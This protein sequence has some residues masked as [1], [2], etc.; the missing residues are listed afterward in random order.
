M[1]KVLLLVGLFVYLS[2]SYAQHLGC[3][4]SHQADALIKQ[5]LMDNRNKFTKQEIK[6]LMNNRTVTYI[7]VSIHNVSNSV[8]EGAATEREIFN[9]LCGLNDLYASQDVQF[10]IYNQINAQTSNAID[11]DASSNASRQAMTG[12]R[13][14]GTMNITIGRS[15]SNP[16][17]SWYS[18]GPDY[19]FLLKQMMSAEAKTEAHEVGHFFTLPHTF[20]GW[21]QT[22]V[23]Q[24]NNQNVPAQVPNQWGWTFTPEHVARTGSQA[25]CSTEGD[26][27]CDTEADYFS[28]RTNC[29]YV[30]LA[31]DPFGNSLTPDDS[32]IMSYASDQCVS[33]FSNQQK[34]AVAMDIATRTWVS[35]TPGSTVDLTAEPATTPVSP[36]NNA[37]LGPISNSTVRID[38]AD[39]NGAT[40]Y[41]LE[42]YGT[43]IPGIW[44]ADATDV[45]YKG[46]LYSSNSYFDLS[47][48]NLQAG[49]RYAW[50]VTP[51]SNYSTCASA[52]PYYRFE[53]SAL[54]TSVK[55]LALEQQMTIKVLEQPVTTS[56]IALAIYTA[57]DVVGSITLYSMDGRAVT[58]LNKQL[59]AAGDNTLQL[60]ASNL[61]NGMYMA[62]LSTERGHLQ[63][64]III[65]K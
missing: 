44:A 31:K 30:V 14:A 11:D 60:P 51:L 15:Q 59:I 28:N 56:N 50:R 21:E 36:A 13:I 6:H 42:V 63:Q 65:Q 40:W 27:F 8:G 19:I 54:T 58:N 1:K 32:N 12:W 33:T 52:S 9:F 7:P 45:I 20:Y 34:A 2:S 22:D 26:G 53:A 61:T 24:Y 17:S 41:Y 37:P 48:T 55:D 35:N 46:Y 10:F 23:S 38:W 39:V 29:P 43:I 49:K 57:E 25:N 4:V 62:V 47:T 5:R 64:K 3:G 18:P 16:T